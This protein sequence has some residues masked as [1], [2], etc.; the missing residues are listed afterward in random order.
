MGDIK[1]HTYNL[2]PDGHNNTILPKGTTGKIIGIPNG[3][4]QTGI[5]SPNSGIAKKEFSL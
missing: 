3:V 4:I 2:Y 5:A 1:A